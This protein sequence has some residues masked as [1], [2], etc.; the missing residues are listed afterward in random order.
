MTL[1]NNGILSYFDTKNINIPK[2]EIDLIEENVIVKL[3]GKH[4]NELEIKKGTVIYLFKVIIKFRLEISF[5]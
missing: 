2:W 5:I 1:S 4:K 3:T